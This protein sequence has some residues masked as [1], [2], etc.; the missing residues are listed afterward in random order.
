MITKSPSNK[1]I[2]NKSIFFTNSARTSF[3]YLLKLIKFKKEELL[4]IPS[5]IGY[6]DREGSGVLDPVIANNINY[7]FYPLLDDLKVDISA[8]EKLIQSNN[9]KALLLIHYFGF[10]YCDINKIKSLCNDYDVL[11]IEDC[12][13]TLYSKVNQN[14]LGEIGDFSFYSLH[15][16]LPTETG[17]ILRINNKRY[18]SEK[19]KIDK[20][21]SIGSSLL[22]TYLR[23]DSEKSITVI[24][25][26]Y[27]F[28]SKELSKING[29]RPMF[30]ILPKG[31]VPMNLPV[32]IEAIS[33][34]DFYFKMINKG[35]TLTSLYYRLV[36][37]IDKTEFPISHEISKKIINFP[38]NQD[39]SID[40]MVLIVDLVK[41]VL[42][43][44]K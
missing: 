36:D 19:V 30:P 6:T 39:I 21:D 23:H 27:N 34:E 18:Q 32:Y 41:R 42:N 5:Y 22:L 37:S 15:K 1:H 43:E 8:I 38:I 20:K 44:S 24:Q 26:N 31:V 10:S 4:L 14:V 33:R 9:V 29:L 13:H 17:G 28:L 25:S 11:L 35:V 2:F 12:A 40:E 16:V 3:S 7:K